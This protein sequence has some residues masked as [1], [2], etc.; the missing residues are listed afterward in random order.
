MEEREEQ[1][2]EET[3]EQLVWPEPSPR[4]APPVHTAALISKEQEDLL[5]EACQ[6]LGETSPKYIEEAEKIRLYIES[7]IYPFD[8][9]SAHTDLVTFKSQHVYSWSVILDLCQLAHL[10]P[11]SSANLPQLLLKMSLLDFPV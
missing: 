4:D 3:T 1:Q 5:T 2:E 11:G 7:S 9:Y 6:R 10:A 8:N